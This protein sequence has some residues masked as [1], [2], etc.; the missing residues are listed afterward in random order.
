V[1]TWVLGSGQDPA[2]RDDATREQLDTALAQDVPVVIDS[3]GL[4][5]SGRATGPAVLTPHA[6]ELAALLGVA[7]ADVVADPAD[8]ARRAADDRNATVLLKGHT[9]FIA[10]PGGALL[11]VTA[12]TTWLATAGT[13]DALAGVLGALVATHAAEVAADRAVLARLA[14][15]ACVL[16][17]AAGERASDGGPLTVLG[18]CAQLPG[19]IA[20]LLLAD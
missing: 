9:S 5:L 4:E 12:P 7:R 20:A 1:Q 13:G 18:L 10:S 16:H 14:A 3:G 15:T 17:G 6:G 11:T 8:S 19:V 2:E